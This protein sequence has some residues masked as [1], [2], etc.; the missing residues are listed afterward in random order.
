MN[1]F[2]LRPYQEEFIAAVRHDFRE[3]DHVLGCAATG[4]GKTILASE[5]MRSWEGN[6]LFLAD[7]K[8][9]VHQNADKYLRYSGE[10]PA[11]EMG[12]SQAQPG[13]RIVIATTQSICR[14]LDKWPR[15]YFDLVIADEAHRNSLGAMAAQVFLH[16][17]QAK[18]LGITA[19]PFRSDRKQL[20]SFFEKIAIEIGL[21]RLIKEGWLARIVIKSVPLNLNLKGVRT[22]AGDYNEEDLGQALLP[23]LREAAQLLVEHA[24]R[25]R[26]VVFLPLI[27][28]SRAFVKACNELGLRAIH[29]DGKDRD[30][31]RAY[32]RGEYDI[33][34][35]A[36]LLTTGWDHPPTD[37]VY[38]LRPTKSLS[39]FQQMVGRGTR[40]ADGKENLLLLDPMFMSDDH[41]L[42]KPA[43]LIAKT[44]EEANE[45]SDL[46]S[47][48]DEKDLLEAEEKREQNRESRL[49]RLLKERSNR[50]SRTI[51][52]MEFCLSLHAVE[53]AEY[54]PELTWEAKP[55]SD[56]QLDALAK[57][58]FDTTG[59]TCRG[60]A[61]KILDLLFTRRRN[62]LA[63]PKQLNYL[64]K[65]GHP[66]PEL[67]SFE[68]AQDWL[69]THFTQ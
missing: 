52:A 22:T 37:C 38:I 50:R 51:D 53:A 61:S 55:P 9:L 28:T 8:E 48:A 54:D 56:R 43:R 10:I 2:N 18:V 68:E 34:S 23:H 30:G 67:V 3:H 15:N 42:I 69:T 57:A 31:L 32:E 35:N 5:L 16:F 40:L 14:R 1:P 45:L 66:Q 49:F 19:T 58:G 59:I 44:E 29:V 41:S 12:D 13:D 26:T 6:C 17:D 33:V 25:R 60:H 7:A 39:L 62:G 20:G 65:T 63:T 4:A 36:S 24:Q 27:A 11:I 21:A 46:L 64:K 47:G